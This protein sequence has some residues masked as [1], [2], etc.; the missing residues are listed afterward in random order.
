MYITE[1]MDDKLFC[2]QFADKYVYS[3]HECSAVNLG[4]NMGHV[5]GWQYI[6]GQNGILLII[7]FSCIEVPMSVCALNLP[8][9]TPAYATA[10]VSCVHNSQLA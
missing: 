1:K 3:N 6:V 4:T 10:G 8:G 7:N 9:P 2:K 5:E